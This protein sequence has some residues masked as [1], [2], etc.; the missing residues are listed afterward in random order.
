MSIYHKLPQCI[1]HNEKL[2]FRTLIQSF[3]LTEVDAQLRLH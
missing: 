3:E 1:I 2:E